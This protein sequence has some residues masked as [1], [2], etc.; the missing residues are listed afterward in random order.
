MKS[1]PASLLAVLMAAQAAAASSPAPSS[2]EPL[3]VYESPADYARGGD[4]T[5]RYPPQL[6]VLQDFVYHDAAVTGPGHIL[7]LRH[8]DAEAGD[9]RFIEINMLRSLKKRMYC[10]D[11]TIC[12]VVDGVVIGTNSEDPDF[13]KAFQ[14]VVASFKRR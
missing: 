3:Q 5:F 12:K 6:V 4:F 14:A 2:Q 8:K 7:V 9:L 10:E 1:L 13:Q 11:Y